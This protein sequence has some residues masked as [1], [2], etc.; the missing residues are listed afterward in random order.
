M[1]KVFCPLGNC[2]G[3][4]HIIGT[5]GGLR[6]VKH[7]LVPELLRLGWRRVDNPKRNYYAEFDKSSPRYKNEMVENVDETD[8]LQVTKI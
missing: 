2:D 1:S 6:H 7:Y 4:L 5:D 3:D 8:F